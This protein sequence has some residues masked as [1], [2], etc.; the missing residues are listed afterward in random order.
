VEFEDFAVLKPVDAASPG[1]MLACAK[2][3]HYRM[4][5]IEI[6]GEGGSSAPPVLSWR[7]EDVTVTSVD[8]TAEGEVPSETVTLSFAKVCTEFAGTDA[9]GRPVK[10]EACWDLKQNKQG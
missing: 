2:G 10:T 9:A 8:F 3:N 1:L 4:A 6:F 7:L 5:R